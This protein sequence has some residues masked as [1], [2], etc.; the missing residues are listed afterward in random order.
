ML[1]DM[2]EFEDF[3]VDVFSADPIV[4]KFLPPALRPIYLGYTAADVIG[5]ELAMRT[6]EAGGAGAID[7]FTPEIRRFEATALVGLGGMII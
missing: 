7:L 2:N 4:L 1:I 6:I 3:F 5:T